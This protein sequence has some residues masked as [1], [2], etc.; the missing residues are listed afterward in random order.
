MSRFIRGTAAIAAV[1]A[2]LMLSGCAPQ[3][4]GETGTEI[5]SA[6][7]ALALVASGASA[8]LVDTRSMP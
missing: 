7:D 8:V 1:A 4:A 3:P 6:A 5:L 2:L